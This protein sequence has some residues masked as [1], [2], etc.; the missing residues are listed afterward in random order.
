MSTAS[1]SRLSPAITTAVTAARRSSQRLRALLPGRADLAAVRRHPRQDLVAGLTVAVVA[2]PLALAFGVASGL[3]AQAGLATA[4]VAGILAAVFGGSNIQVSGPTGAMTV[5]LVPVVAQHGTSGVLMVGLLA[6]LVLVALA[7]SGLGRFV[8]YL[9]VS[10]VEGFTAGIAVVISLQQ[11]PAALGV[12]DATGDKV[13][14]VAADAVR[15]FVEHP[16]PA[17]L[18]VAL[19]VAALI[20]AGGR[21]H[22]RVPYSLVAITLA[23]VVARLGGWDLVTL[24][25]LPSTLPAPSLGFVDLSAVDTLATAAL[26]I[27]ALAALESLLCATVA[28]AMTV[29]ERHDPDREL[30]GQGV[31]N[32]VAPMFGGIPATAAIARTAVNVRA[33]A[34]SR[35]AAVSHALILLLLVFVAAPLVSAIPLAALA[36]VLFA[37]CVRMV[38]ASSLLALLRSTR[39]DALIV[40]LTF[41]VTV[42]L[43]LVTAVGVGVAVAVVLALRT[44]A[45]SARLDEVALDGDLGDDHSDEEHA[46][47]AEHVVVYRIDGPLFFAAAHRLLLELPDLVEVDVVIIRMSRVSSMDA[48]GA[49]VLGDTITRLERRDIAVLL[50]SLAPEHEEVLTSLGVGGPLRTAGRILP[51]TPSA[52]AV[53]RRL[54]AASR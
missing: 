36:G 18:L 8:R 27:A 41:T 24:G 22:P 53:A 46:L 29:N 28:D 49:H 10:V 32:I 12:A 15:R 40:V 34:G 5:V 54:L 4:V 1:T 31:A 17:P 14:A 45:A 23:T 38:E 25:H 48:T 19:G 9:P 50:S 42:A 33:G 51:D 43:D 16:A 7:L 47:L 26:A 21:W 3:G 44:V 6:G 30:F 20:L 52:I 2:L 35:L 13:W 11:V 37:T 39:S